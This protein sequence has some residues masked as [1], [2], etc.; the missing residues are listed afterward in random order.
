MCSKHI[1]CVGLQLGA[2]G[3]G[4]SLL[5]TDRMGLLLVAD[6]FSASWRAFIGAYRF[7][8]CDLC[9]RRGCCAAVVPPPLF[10]LFF[11]HHGSIRTFLFHFDRLRRIVIHGF[12]IETGQPGADER[13]QTC[14]QKCGEEDRA[15]R[16]S[17]SRGNRRQ[18]N[19]CK[20]Q[21]ESTREARLHDR[22]S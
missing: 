4:L 13:A 21:N 3:M 19:S 20:A 6:T 9:Q 12:H 22:R 14:I 16:L 15:E 18:R 1:L 7:M 11:R 5:G 8:V 2:D 10:I 17:H